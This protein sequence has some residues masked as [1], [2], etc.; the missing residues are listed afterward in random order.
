MKMLIIN[1]SIGRDAILLGYRG[2]YLNKY[3][4]TLIFNLSST[5]YLRG[6][7]I[8]AATYTLFSTRGFPSNF[9]QKHIPLPVNLYP[10]HNFAVPSTSGS[11]FVL[12]CSQVLHTLPLLSLITPLNAACLLPTCTTSHSTCTSSPTLTALTYF[13]SNT[14]LTPPNIQKPGLAIAARARVVQLS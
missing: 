11:I 4:D 1:C 13:T 2:L 10:L 5:L 3:T 8:S 7:L 9:R 6:L 12:S 14:L